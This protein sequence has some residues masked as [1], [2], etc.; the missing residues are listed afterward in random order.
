[1][2]LS[3]TLS[4]SHAPRPRKESRCSTQSPRNW[5]PNFRQASGSEEEIANRQKRTNRSSS[6]CCVICH[7]TTTSL[8]LMLFAFTCS[9]IGV[10]NHWT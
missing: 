9:E 1:M 3:T 5:P 10:L 6:F 2:S 8:P 4:A 7:L